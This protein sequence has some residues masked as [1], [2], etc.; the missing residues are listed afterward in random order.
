VSGDE[1]SD[2]ADFVD[3]LRGLHDLS[4]RSES[5]A[6][7]NNSDLRRRSGASGQNLNALWKTRVQVSIS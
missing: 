7:S 2:E 5:E 3:F 1:A 6:S 4:K